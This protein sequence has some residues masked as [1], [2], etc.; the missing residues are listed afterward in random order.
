MEL[1]AAAGDILQMK[2]RL[3]VNEPEFAA[4][5]PKYGQLQGH[6]VEMTGRGQF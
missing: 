6:S 3:C 1:G 2:L 5:Q 4:V